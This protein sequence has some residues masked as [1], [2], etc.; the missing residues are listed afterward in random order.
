MFIIHVDQDQSVFLLL[1]ETLEGTNKKVDL[2]RFGG[3]KYDTLYHERDFIPGRL[4]TDN[5]ELCA[6]MCSRAI[7][8]FDLAIN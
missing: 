1:K 2:K 4:I 8:I 7:I 3:Y 5:I 6:R